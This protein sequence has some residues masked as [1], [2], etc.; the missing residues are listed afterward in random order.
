MRA[1]PSL[2]MPWGRAGGAAGLFLSAV[3]A[4]SGAATVAEPQWELLKSPHFIIRYQG[5]R[6]FAQD[7]ERRAEASYDRIAR[8]LDITRYGDF[9]VWDRRARIDVYA[10][11]EAYLAASGAPPWSAGVALYTGRAILTFAGSQAFLDSVLPHELTHLIFREFIGFKVA[12]PLWLDEGVAQWEDEVNRRKVTAIAQ[13]LRAQGRLQPVAALTGA[14]PRRGASGRE[15]VEFYA[16]AASLVG[17]MQE[18]YGKPHFREFCGHLRDGRSLEDALRFT[19]PDTIRS[20]EALDAAWKSHLE[21]LPH[22]QTT[23]GIYT[24]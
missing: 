2:R 17:F 24:H 1:P 22:E 6:D 20:V 13:S 5:R 4:A 8:N 10:T 18:S 16:Q 3:L 12:I 7:V 19:Y 11:R 9:W 15:A 23:G 14:D 21:V